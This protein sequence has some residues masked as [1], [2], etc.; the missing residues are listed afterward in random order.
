MVINVNEPP[1]IDDAEPD[2]GLKGNNLSTVSYKENRTS[3]STDVLYSATDDEDDAANPRKALKWSLSGPDMELFAICEYVASDSACT[4]PV[5]ATADAELSFKEIPD[6]ESPSD[7]NGDNVYNVTVTV[8]DSHDN[9]DTRDVAVTV[10][11][12]EEDGEVTVKNLVPEV[13]IPI[14][15]AA[16]RSRRRRKGHKLEVVG[17]KSHRPSN[18]A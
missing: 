10:T 15:A 12:E 3:T 13:G 16:V 2:A 17:L 5:V 18:P 8:T 11:N 7:A 9:T 14:E 6:F 1:K 4:S